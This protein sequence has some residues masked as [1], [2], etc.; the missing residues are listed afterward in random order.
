MSNNLISNNPATPTLSDLIKLLDPATLDLLTERLHK[1]ASVQEEA[2]E[3]LLFSFIED[4]LA[5]YEEDEI[6]E[7]KETAIRAFFDQLYSK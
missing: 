1:V 6:D 2:P 4:C 3:Q 5:V 7:K